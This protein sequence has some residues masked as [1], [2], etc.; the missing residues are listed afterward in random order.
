MWRWISY[1]SSWWQIINCFCQIILFLRELMQN[2]AYTQY[3]R[4]CRCRMVVRFTTTYISASTHC[5]LDTLLCYKVCQWLATG[6][7]F[8]LGI[9]VSSTNKTDHN[10]IAEKLLKVAL[11]TI[12]ITILSTKLQH[13]Q[14]SKDTTWL[15]H[16]GLK[17][18]N[19]SNISYV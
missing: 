2:V 1:F 18:Q 10:D 12:A 17:K 16:I 9:P 14:F 11:N 19:A 4:G 7:W 8:S 6:R 15:C 5:V 13:L 3:N